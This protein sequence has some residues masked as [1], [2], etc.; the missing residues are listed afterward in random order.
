[1]IFHFLLTCVT[2]FYV[3]HLCSPP[4]SSLHLHLT[5][6]LVVFVFKRVL[7]SVSVVS[8]LCYSPVRVSHLV[9]LLCPFQCPPVSPRDMFSAFSFWLLFL[10]FPDLYFAFYC[11]LF[12]FGGLTLPGCFFGLYVSLS[13]LLLFLILFASLCILAFGPYLQPCPS[14]DIRYKKALRWLGLDVYWICSL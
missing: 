8:I 14:C 10:L 4:P 13:I 3:P 2:M 6:S 7:H 9:T 5:P 1:M 11:A 12:K